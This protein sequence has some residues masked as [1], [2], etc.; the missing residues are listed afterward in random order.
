MGSIDVKEPSFARNI[1]RVEQSTEEVREF[2]EGENIKSRLHSAKERGERPVIRAGQI[3]VN[4]RRICRA[5]A[6]V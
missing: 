2:L 3:F 1:V 4:G 6:G 5:D